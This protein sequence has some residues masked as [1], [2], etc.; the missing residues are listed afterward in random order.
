MQ[1]MANPT[2]IKTMRTAIMTTIAVPP[3]L[4]GVSFM[5]TGVSESTLFTASV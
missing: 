1:E 5:Y 3:P 4:F 2:G